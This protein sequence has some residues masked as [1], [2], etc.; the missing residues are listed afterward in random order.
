MGANPSGIQ[1]KRLDDV[2]FT[3]IEVLLSV[4]IIALLIAISLPALSR[5]RGTAQRT[6]SLANLRS[7]GQAFEMYTSGSDDLYPSSIE[8]RLYPM[9][10]CPGVF[11]TLPHW[12]AANNWPGLVHEVLPWPAHGP[13][14]FLAPGARRDFGEYVS[15]CGLPP[16][17]HYS[18]AFIT[19]PELWRPGA[20]ADP[21]LRKGTAVHEVVFPSSKVLMWDWELPYVRRELRFQGR[22]L[23]E[24]A[25]MLFADGHG[26][27]LAP[28]AATAPMRNPFE[29]VPYP[30][31][32]LHNTPDG[33]RG[34]DF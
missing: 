18:T 11:G 5:V 1:E 4:S 6:Q 14:V 16:S 26:D 28:A 31:H 19:R 33:V 15:T 32:R 29:G 23:A 9:G 22:D 30:E 2:G 20:V 24:P 7:I 13:G 8:G 10:W 27:Q 25:P 17:Y 21:V 34:R 12:E 3:L